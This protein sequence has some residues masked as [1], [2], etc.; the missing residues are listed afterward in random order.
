[1]P[2]RAQA[3]RGQL[4]LFYSGNQRVTWPRVDANL[5]TTSGRMALSDD[6]SV[7]AT[8]QLKSTLDPEVAYTLLAGAPSYLNNHHVLA[9]FSGY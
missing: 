3:K 1:M 6:W 5:L 4:M 2:M 9:G 7:R 8:C